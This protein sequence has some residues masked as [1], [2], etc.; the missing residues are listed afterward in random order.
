M[1]EKR[2]IL[3]TI[4]KSNY[5]DYSRYFYRLFNSYRELQQHLYKFRNTPRY[6]IFEETNQKKDKSFKIEKRFSG[7]NFYE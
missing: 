1:K 2:Y 6:V 3:M 5:D 4:E 7:I